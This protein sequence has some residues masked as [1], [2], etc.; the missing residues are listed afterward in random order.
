MQ[1]LRF[2]GTLLLLLLTSESWFLSA[3]DEVL[4]RS[5]AVPSEQKKMITRDALKSVKVHFRRGF[6]KIGEDYMGN[7]ETLEQ[8][9]HEVNAYYND[10]TARFRR[11]RITASVSPEG[12]K[13]IN[14]R[15][16]KQRAEAIT[17]WIGQ[18]MS[19]D[20]EFEVVATG[21]DWH[22]LD[23]LVQA[24]PEVPHRR[25]V[26]DIIA[27]APTSGAASG[28]EASECYDRLRRLHKGAPYE[29]IEE[30]LFPYMR[31]AEARA[32]FWW[33]ED[34]GLVITS[35]IPM[36]F[37]SAETVSAITYDKL[38]PDSI[39]PAQECSA[40]WITITHP[41]KDSIA[42]IVAANP[43]TEPR[44]T[45]IDLE[46]YGKIYSVAI[47]QAPAD[48]RLSITT[49]SPLTFPARGGQ[50]RIR[51]TRNTTSDHT[52]PQAQASEGWIT[53]ILPTEQY[54][55]FTVA[56]N[57][58]RYSRTDTIEVSCYGETHE[59]EIL[60]QH[61]LY[62]ALK[63]NLLYDVAMIPNIGV[64]LYLGKNI[65]VVA[66]WQYAWWHKR[67][68]E[69]FH[70]L[71]GGDLALR[72]WWGKEAAYKPL[73]GHHIGLYGQMVTYDFEYGGR[74]YL[75]DRW[76][77]AAGL[78]YGYSL[79]IASRF[80]L[81]FTLGLGYHWGIYDEYLPIDGHSVWQR[82][83]NRQYIGPT[84]LEVSLVWLLGRGNYNDKKG[85]DR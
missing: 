56:P 57:N 20:V 16:V 24:T 9:A 71:Y 13:E 23:S 83:S 59:V 80:N 5:H 30:H 50:G 76:S 37:S 72:Y 19:I 35:P 43:I 60:Q 33:E 15:L 42:F 44:S 64:E 66:N 41:T 18:K 22:V 84:K 2:A 6:S 55:D 21:I 78:E 4:S 65:S 17:R 40:D 51:F 67:S 25:E 8:F 47:H 11:I 46:Y 73:T 62:Y 63:S 69:W 54:V 10:S 1:T 34:P 74:G 85:G 3:Q 12:S 38:Y 26:L 53:S 36:Q 31:Y 32:E 45:Q 70:R 79:P 68:W 82:T 27:S 58:T 49:P 52:V 39:I 81:D 48:Y 61:T 77:W 7:K 75:A 29:W 14:E 28:V